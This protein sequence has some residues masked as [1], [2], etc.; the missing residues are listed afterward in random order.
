MNVVYALSAYP[1]GA[2]SDR[3]DRR[4]IL[5]A[6]VILLIAADLVLAFAQGVSGVALGV[7]LWGLHMGMTQG[8]FATLVADV[9]QPELRGTAFGVFNLLC[10]LAALLA[11]VVAGALWDATG[12][13]G[14]FLGGVGFALLTLFGL[15]VF[16]KLPP[17]AVL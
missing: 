3:M 14:A 4:A 13:Q 9:A 16:R 10:G 8:L 12:P 5:M 1:A 2:L 7:M 15:L 17:N 6:G 11:S